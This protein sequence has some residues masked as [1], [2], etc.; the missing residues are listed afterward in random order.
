MSPPGNQKLETR[1]APKAQA[2]VLVRLGAGLG[3]ESPA[4]H[5]PAFWAIWALSLVL[6]YW[7]IIGGERGWSKAKGKTKGA[8]GEVGKEIRDGRRCTMPF[9]NGYSNLYAVAMSSP[10]LESSAASKRSVFDLSL[11]LP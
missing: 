9:T 2:T 3:I 5:E 1:N 11:P 10:K 8:S 4:F 6:G 7:L